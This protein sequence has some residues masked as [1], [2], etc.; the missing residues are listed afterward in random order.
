MDLKDVFLN[1]EN[2]KNLSKTRNIR[3][4]TIKLIELFEKE[5]FKFYPEWRGIHR[6]GEYR[7]NYTFKVEQPTGKLVNII[8]VYPMD[9]WLKVEVYRG[10]YDKTHYSVFQNNIDDYE[11]MK[12]M[13]YDV[14][15]IY[16]SIS[17]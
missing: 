8:T 5:G 9:G 16:N 15:D 2:F 13:L 4:L 11:Q 6:S 1:N 7:K 17:I 3:E 12:P 10:Q 14:R